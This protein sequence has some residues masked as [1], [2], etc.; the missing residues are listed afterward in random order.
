MQEEYTMIHFWFCLK[1][2]HANFEK[3]WLNF[4]KCNLS[5]SLPS[6]TTNSRKQA[7]CSYLVFNKQTSSLF[8]SFHWC[9][10]IFQHSNVQRNSETEFLWGLLLR[11]GSFKWPRK[12]VSVYQGNDKDQL[13]KHVDQ[14]RKSTLLKGLC[15]SQCRHGFLRGRTRIRFVFVACV[16]AVSG[17]SHRFLK[18]FKIVN[19][20]SKT[21]GVDDTCI[22]LKQSLRLFNFLLKAKRFTCEWLVLLDD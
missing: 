10:G 6:A 2:M 1:D 13:D 16:W 4:S 14:K 3:F 8:L 17:R 15:N 19:N 5:P 18:L 21:D 11:S 9:E 12:F 22:N 20:T 7:Q